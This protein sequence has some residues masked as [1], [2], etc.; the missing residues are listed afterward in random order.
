M[1]SE[2]FNILHYL[3]NREWNPVEPVYQDSK[4]LILNF[5]GNWVGLSLT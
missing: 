4:K 5:L 1:N 2:S 3:T